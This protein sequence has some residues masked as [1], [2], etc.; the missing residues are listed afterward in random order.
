M[1]ESTFI[2]AESVEAVVISGPQKGEIIALPDNTSQVSDEVWAVLNEGL[3]ELLAAIER[4]HTSVCSF[5]ES[6]KKRQERA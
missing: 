2:T 3:D 4:L 6:L 5:T 1:S